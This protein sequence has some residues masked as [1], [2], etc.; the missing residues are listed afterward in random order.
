[1]E[2]EQNVIVAGA[3]NLVIDTVMHHIENTEGL[4]LAE[5]VEHATELK[6]TSERL[7]PDCIL[8]CPSLFDTLPE[9][10][11]VEFLQNHNSFNLLVTTLELEYEAIRDLLVAGV[12]GIVLL[13]KVD[14][15]EMVAAIN[16]VA[17]GQR[18]L[19][20]D[21]TQMLCH[22]AFQKPQNTVLDEV[23][24]ERETEISKLVADGLSSKEIAK[25]LEISPATVSVHR[26]NIMMKTGVNKATALAKLVHAAS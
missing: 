8:I 21:I 3:R 4:T 13:R 10:D 9:V 22:A 24:T 1:M 17:L 11:C 12:K 19:S 2:M 26:R 15:I 14:L 16:A 7:K 25:I 23:L 18:Y 6:P 20:N 5:F